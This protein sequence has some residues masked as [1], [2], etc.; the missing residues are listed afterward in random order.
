MKIRNRKQSFAFSQ[1]PSQIEFWERYLFFLHF[2]L[3]KKIFSLKNNIYFFWKQKIREKNSYQTYPK[4]QFS[5]KIKKNVFKIKNLFPKNCFYFFKKICF[6]KLFSKKKKN[7]F[8]KNVYKI[9]I[10]KKMSVF[11]KRGNP[12]LKKKIYIYIN[13]FQSFSKEIF[14]K[15]V[16]LHTKVCF[17]KCFLKKI[18]A[19][20]KKKK[21][22]S[23]ILLPR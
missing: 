6:L 23:K 3:S 9:F 19:F 21:K 14:F 18:H 11:L 17:Q 8:S 10:K 15:N 7:L 22:F 12:K 16:F 13:V 1:F 2:G 4:N 20:Q 5:K